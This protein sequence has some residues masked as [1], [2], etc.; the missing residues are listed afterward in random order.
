MSQLTKKIPRPLVEFV[1]KIITNFYIVLMRIKFKR[2][3]I[4]RNTSDHY[5]FRDIFLFKEFKLP[6][7]INPKLIVD[8]GAYIGLSS[9]YYSSKFPNAQIIA[10]EPESSNFDILTKNT[11]LNTKIKRINAGVWSKNTHLK[12]VNSHSEKWAFTVQEVDDS[13]SN[14]IKAITIDEILK[15]SGFNEIDILKI[16][17][18]GSEKEI[19][20]KNSENWLKKVKIIVLELHDRL[21]PGCS[22]SVYNSLNREEWEEHKKGEKVIFIKKQF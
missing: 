15:V 10:I 5:V 1:L 2:L 7:N 19:F 17:I 13:D 22:E 11:E 14:G 4:R 3:I 9:L 12:I 21:I 16:D 6:V 8:T 20:S 18:E